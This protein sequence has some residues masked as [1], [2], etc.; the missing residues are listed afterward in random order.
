M[1][2]RPFDARFAPFFQWIHQKCSFVTP[3]FITLTRIIAIV[4]F[5][6]TVHYNTLLEINLLLLLWLAIFDIFDGVLAR[7]TNQIT[8]LGGFLDQAVDKIGVMCCAYF[9][10]VVHGDI[11]EPIQGIPIIWYSLVGIF[12]CDA[13]NL[14]IRILEG[15]RDSIAH[16][17]ELDSFW[18]HSYA[19]TQEP[20]AVSSIFGKIKVWFLMIGL[21][22]WSISY[23]QHI[24]NNHVDG[25]LLLTI[26]T[27]IAWLICIFLSPLDNK[28]ILVVF[29]A[30]AGCMFFSWIIMFCS[31]IIM[32]YIGNLIIVLGLSLAIV[33]TCSQVWRRIRK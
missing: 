16:R 14:I 22:F 33:S 7:T 21:C 29:A 30:I 6:L 17:N 18:L 5:V 19:P 2:P 20:K 12:S 15:I 13:L 11:L 10:Y 32:G 3:T 23:S 31:P 24:I 1:N 9:L 25:L 27:C 26:I 8:R 4:L 28:S